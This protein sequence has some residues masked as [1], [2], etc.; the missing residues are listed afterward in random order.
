[1]TDNAASAHIPVM[2]AEVL[3]ALA[4]EPGGIYVDATFGAGGY[5]RALLD[6]TDCRVIAVDRDPD[7]M[8]LAQAIQATYEERFKFLHGRFSGLASLLTNEGVEKVDGIVF[9]IGVSS[10]QID[11]PERGFSFKNSGPLDMRMSQEGTSAMDIVNSYGEEELADILYRY[12][13]ERKSRRIARAIVDKRAEAPIETTDALAAI[14]RKALG[15]PPAPTDPATRSFQ[16][17]RIYVNRELDE[18]QA[19]LAAIP[20]LL[21]AGGRMAVVTFHSLEDRIVKHWLREQEGIRPISR[22]MPVTAQEKATL[23][24]FPKIMPSEAEIARNPRARSARLR[25]AERLA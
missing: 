2:L 18:L 19:A 6:A 13:E 17:L 25:Y 10:I 20:G 11:R 15:G 4:P 9:D 23:R 24:A 22:H 3:E 8:A 5:S 14:I 1:M 21:K 12:G 16:A 7:A